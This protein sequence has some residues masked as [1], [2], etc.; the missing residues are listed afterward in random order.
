[1][2]SEHAVRVGI[3]GGTHAKGRE[4][5]ISAGGRKKL[6]R[7]KTVAGSDAGVSN[8]EVGFLMEFGVPKKIPA[9]S[10]LRMP[11]TQ[12]ISNIVKNAAVEFV[13][14]VESGDAV[15]FMK[16]LGISAEAEIQRAFAT[17]GYGGWEPNKPSTVARKGSASP[18]IDTAQ[19]RRSVASQV[20]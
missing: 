18:L 19:L 8:A 16:R 11:L 10:W 13:A 5:S 7:V 15:R 4:L 17:S 1:M 12:K 9:R 14:A 20:T 2:E 6:R 3:F